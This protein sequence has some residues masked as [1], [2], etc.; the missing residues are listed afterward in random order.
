MPIRP[1]KPLNDDQRTVLVGFG[2]VFLILSVVMLIMFGSEAGAL[3]LGTVG[4]VLAMWSA[5]APE[6]GRE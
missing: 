2:T 4:L 3:I 1:L 6:P 5:V